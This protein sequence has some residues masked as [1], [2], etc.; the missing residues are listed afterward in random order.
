[1]PNEQSGA[2]FFDDQKRER[3]WAVK[4][5]RRERAPGCAGHPG[6]DDDGRRPQE[7]PRLARQVAAA[8]A[9]D[10]RRGHELHVRVGFGL[11]KRPDDA[12][13]GNPARQQP[14]G[15]VSEIRPVFCGPARLMAQSSDHG[16]SQTFRW[17]PR[18]IPPQ[19]AGRA[20]SAEVRASLEAV[21][22]AQ[23]DARVRARRQTCGRGSGLP[24]GGGRRVGGCRRRSA[25][26]RG[27][28]ARPRV[29]PPTPV[30]TAMTTTPPPS[31]SGRA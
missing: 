9:A 13:P 31:P 20:L 29:S 12:R 21:R 23:V 16:A 17:R 27:R 3:G 25:A 18:R 22:V 6:C 4:V 1:M 28:H 10:R 11:R 7:L 5:V 15:I 8:R 30:T 2:R 24:P 19:S 26:V 14:S